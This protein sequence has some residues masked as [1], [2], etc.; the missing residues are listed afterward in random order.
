MSN[1]NTDFQSDYG[2]KSTKGIKG[3]FNSFV[4]AFSGVFHCI[5]NER[6]IRIHIVA[7]L[8]VFTLSPFYNFTNAQYAVLLIICGLVISLEMI[9]TAVEA[10]CDYIS[11]N[12][13]EMARV[14]K[15]LVA[16]AVVIA[17]CVAL[18]IGMLFFGDL[19]IIFKILGFLYDRPLVA[20]MFLCTVIS[21]ILFIKDK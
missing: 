10:I 13:S 1:K 8:F 15:N 3:L 19:D 16:G 12:Y 14:A 4:Y 21:S 7:A 20:I 6:N 2:K 18:I 9:N 17:A 5:L 11:P